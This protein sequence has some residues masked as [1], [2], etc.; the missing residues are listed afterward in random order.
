MGQ[1]PCMRCMRCPPEYLHSLLKACRIFGVR[2]IS[3][4]SHALPRDGG[5]G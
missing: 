3:V 5:Y 2:I 1:Q 4:T